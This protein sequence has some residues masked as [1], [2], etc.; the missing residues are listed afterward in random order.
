METPKGSKSADRFDLLLMD[1]GEYYFKDYLCNYHPSEEAHG[2][3]QGHLKVCSHSVFFVPRNMHDAVFRIAFEDTLLVEKYSRAMK[4]ED[5]PQPGDKAFG[6]DKGGSG[7]K[8]KGRKGGEHSKDDDGNQKIAEGFTVYATQRTDMKFG[9]RNTSYVRHKG[10]P[11]R[12]LGAHSQ[13]LCRRSLLL[14]LPSE[15]LSAD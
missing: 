7:K 4:E 14:G 6:K 1:E 5:T 3:V 8:A 13:Q 10:M 12:G 9:N 11:A 2:K 15:H